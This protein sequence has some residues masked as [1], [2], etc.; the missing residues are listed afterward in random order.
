MA[1]V[2]GLYTGMAT[3]S[4]SWTLRNAA[5]NAGDAC[6]VRL[7]RLQWKVLV[8]GCWLEVVLLSPSSYF[9][10]PDKTINGEADWWGNK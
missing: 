6:E 7:N 8:L 9:S 3:G 10:P 5:V 4:R 1:V 2:E